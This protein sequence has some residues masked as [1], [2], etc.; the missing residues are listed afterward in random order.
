MRRWASVASVAASFLL[1]ASPAFGQSQQY[2]LNG[3]TNTDNMLNYGVS[4]S[5]QR[6]HHA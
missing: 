1:F 3:S 5:Q 2:L 4:Y 6:K